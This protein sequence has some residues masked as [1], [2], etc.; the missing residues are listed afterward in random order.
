MT[1]RLTLR[2][3]EAFR[4]VMTRKSVTG[5]AEILGVTQPVVT[6][7]ISDLEERVAFP[8]FTR[9]KGRLIATAEASLLLDDVQQALL[10]V[11]RITYASSSI[12]EL[13]QGKLLVAAAPAIALCCL[14]E[15]IASF[16]KENPDTLISLHMESSPT[17]LEMAYN[18]RCD[19]GFAMLPTNATAVGNRELLLSGRMVG[20]VPKWH[21]L[22]SAEVLRPADFAGENFISMSRL[23]E[24][25]ALI[26]PIFMAH[27]VQR[28]IHIETQISLAVVRHVE[29]GA[30]ISVIDPVTAAGYRSDLVK[31]IRFEPAVAN[32]YS[33]VTS[34]KR[35][36]P[37]IMR[38]F[39][40]HVR[41]HIKEMVPPDWWMEQ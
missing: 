19:L 28:H 30:G 6:R 25:R 22:A 34:P 14:P 3:L 26:D 21:R 39:I 15:A 35:Q 24:A 11:D 36:A 18:G 1:K 32:D 16:S 7:L 4:A 12:R 17:V 33:L 38:P 41:R 10:S 5:A 9:E 2:H 40:E 37:L 8:L 20:V 27:N 31:Y 13:K 29:A 23:I